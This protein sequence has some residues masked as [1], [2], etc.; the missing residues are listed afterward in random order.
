MRFVSLLAALCGLPSLLQCQPAKRALII[1]N[2]TY[3]KLPPVPAFR[4]SAI[5]IEN[6]VRNRGFQ[7]TLK[8]DLDLDAM[9]AETDNFVD[10]VK[11][12]D[13]VFFYYSGYGFQIPNRNR[14]YLVPVGCDP[15]NADLGWDGQSYVADY[16]LRQLESR[17]AGLRMAVLDAAWELQG[18]SDINQGLTNIIPTDNTMVWFP[19]R[20]G[21]VLKLPSGNAPGLFASALVDAMGT[22]GLNLQ[23]LISAVSSK[24]QT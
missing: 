21:K 23:Q 2:A 13:I 9:K 16:L 24:V 7:T 12:G 6:A 10:T 19:T 17:K 20:P 5:A 22:R 14:N 8:L 4:A 18:L 3:R 1:G 11:T 15:K